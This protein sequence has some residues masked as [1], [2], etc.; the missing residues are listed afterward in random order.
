MLDIP[1]SLR[2]IVKASIKP[3]LG[4]KVGKELGRVV[5]KGLGIGE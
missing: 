2:V 3:T 4:A 5:V 1:N